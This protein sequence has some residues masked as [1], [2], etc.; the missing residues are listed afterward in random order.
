[1]ECI[2][3]GERSSPFFEDPIDARRY[4]HCSNCDLRYLAPEFR[5][6]EAQEKARYQFHENRAEDPSYQQFMRPVLEMVKPEMSSIL[7]FGCGVASVLRYFHPEKVRL[8]DPYF[9]PDETP[10]A[11][12]YDL[13]AA[14][15][16]IEHLYYPARELAR[17][18]LL[19]KPGGS[20]GLMTLMASSS[21]HFADWYY[22]RDPTHVA[23]YSRNTFEWIRDHFKFRELILISQR[24]VELR[25]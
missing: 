9:Y 5:L 18:R 10:L 4:L 11:S 12:T 21:I 22:R 16:V 14:V 25:T 19:L 3:C 7:D 15:E 6:T 17:L 24:A 23:F 1:M 2:L 8:Y 13:I 20:L